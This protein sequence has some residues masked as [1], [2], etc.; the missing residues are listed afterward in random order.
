M[1]QL[2]LNTFFSYTELSNKVNGNNDGV[3]QAFALYEVV[4]AAS[5]NEIGG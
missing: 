2:T 1:L 3:P 4:E 5:S